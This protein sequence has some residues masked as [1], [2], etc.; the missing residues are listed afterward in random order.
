MK[1]ETEIDPNGGMG[2]GWH[3]AW[4]EAG[5]CCAAFAAG[6]PAGPFQCPCSPTDRAPNSQAELMQML[7]AFRLSIAKQMLGRQTTQGAKHTCSAGTG[8]HQWLISWCQP[9]STHL[10]WA[11]AMRHT[12][13]SIWGVYTCTQDAQQMSEKPTVI[14]CTWQC[15]GSAAAPSQ[16]SAW[17][18]RA[19]AVSC[20]G[21]VP[22]APLH[23]C[24]CLRC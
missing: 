6:N 16:M 10:K 12:S 1:R 24:P 17:L 15:A 14:P 20:R 2:Q 13:G 19:P 18:S 4:S 7:I 3:L 11:L 22:C 23:L 21:I 9:A 5:G 8:A